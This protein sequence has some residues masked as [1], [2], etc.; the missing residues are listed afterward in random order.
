MRRRPKSVQTLL[1]PARSAAAFLVLL[2]LLLPGR[3][4]AQLRVGSATAAEAALGAARRQYDFVRDQILR[5][6]REAPEE[7]YAYQP[8]DDALG[9]G[10]LIGHLANAA[11]AFCSVAMG[12][13]SPN[14]TD[15]ELVPEKTRLV[16]A[17][18]DGYAYCDRV[19][20]DIRAT[21]L[22]DQVELFG[23]RG[24]RIWVL[25]FNATHNWEHYGN[26]LVYLQVN[27]FELPAPPGGG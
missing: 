25:V 2:S 4:E 12:E 11:F 23:Q 15:W 5:I 26:L 7:L 3:G 1:L 13:P 27:G 10:Q 22:G 18:E 9:F 19:H 20:R 14:S 24:T 16:V 6:A 21:S 17:L 8:S